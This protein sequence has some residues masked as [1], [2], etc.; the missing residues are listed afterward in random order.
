MVCPITQ[1]DHKINVVTITTT[2]LRPIYRTTCVSQH[3]Q[4]RTGGFCLCKVLLPTCLCWRQL[5]HSD[6]GEDAEFSLMVL[7]ALALYHRCS[8]NFQLKIIKTRIDS[9]AKEKNGSLVFMM[10]AYDHRLITQFQPAQAH[11]MFKVVKKLVVGHCGSKTVPLR[12]KNGADSKFFHR[13]TRKI[14]GWL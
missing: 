5:A 13:H 3:L 9:T 2:V 12:V 4:L 11:I 6:L 14:T 8:K 1:G 10:S 7:P